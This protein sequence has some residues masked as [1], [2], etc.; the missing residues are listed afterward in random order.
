MHR[1]EQSGSVKKM[2]HKPELTELRLNE[3]K[4]QPINDLLSKS[5]SNNENII[6]RV[7]S[8]FSGQGS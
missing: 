8:S 5:D 6:H 3:T 4:A 2:W 7:G 1:T